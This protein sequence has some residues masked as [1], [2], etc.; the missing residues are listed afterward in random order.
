MGAPALPG[1]GVGNT[2]ILAGVKGNPG[3]TGAQLAK[4]RSHGFAIFADRVIF[5]AQPPMSEA[6]IEN[7][8]QQCAGPLPEPLLALWRTTAGGSLDYDLS[9]GTGEYVEAL[10]WVELFHHGSDGVKDLQ[11]WIDHELE[12]MPGNKAAGEKLLALPIG[13]FEYAERI[14]VFVGPGPE[15]GAVFAWTEGPPPAWTK[16][17]HGK[18]VARVADD[19]Y[20]AFAALS[21]TE[22]PGPDR[23]LL[24][25]IEEKVDEGLGG[26]LARKLVEYYRRAVTDWNGLVAGGVRGIAPEAARR[27]LAAAIKR[28]DA[29]Y[30][31]KLAPQVALDRPILGMSFPLEAAAALGKFAAVG[32]LLEA[33]APIRV[34]DYMHEDTPLSLVQALLDRGAEPAIKDIVECALH[35]NYANADL[36]ARAYAARHEDLVAGF[37]KARTAQLAQKRKDLE[38]IK[39]DRFDYPGGDKALMRLI[40]HLETYEL[41]T[42]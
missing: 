20:G 39:A 30:I 24:Q 27:A 19:L 7:V 6:A 21:L 40:E 10:S 4:L 35:G 41:P 13:G 28:D 14:Y 37:K 16:R 22:A 9:A 5:D 29:A 34:L 15:H 11:G 1:P 8:Q 18:A 31:R 17:D 2:G 26:A 42:K 38:S 25:R 23:T 32:A 36:I 33:G 12:Q 3:F